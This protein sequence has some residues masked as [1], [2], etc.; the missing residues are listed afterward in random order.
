MGLAGFALAHACGLQQCL[1]QQALQITPPHQLVGVGPVVG[2]DDVLWPECFH[3]SR[4][5]RLFANPK[6]GHA[7]RLSGGVGIPQPLIEA[8]A[9]IHILIKLQLQRKS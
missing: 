4:T 2:T 9:L 6:M 5:D 7:Q 1:R 8:A 3:R